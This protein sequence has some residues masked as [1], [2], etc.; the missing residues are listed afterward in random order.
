M[1]PAAILQHLLGIGGV[2]DIFNG[3]RCGI[4]TFDCV[5]PTRAARHGNALVMA[6]HWESLAGT[7]DDNE[8]SHRDE[9]ERP[10]VPEE[11]TGDRNIS[12]GP[13]VIKEIAQV[14]LAI[15]SIRRQLRVHELVQV[16]LFERQLRSPST[17]ST[18]I[19]DK[20]RDRLMAD[21]VRM[22]SRREGL[23]AHS[24]KKD[25]KTTERC[26]ENAPQQI[27]PVSGELL[28]LVADH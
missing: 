14:D 19:S 7:A 18:A 12:L 5:M 9:K 24:V 23:I 10:S 6:H 11:H 3:V 26:K 21:L 16:E 20:R 25:I 15:E 13:E 8:N 2:V 22:L 4:D 27:K 17:A 28:L 1:H